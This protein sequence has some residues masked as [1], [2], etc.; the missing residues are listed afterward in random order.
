MIMSV[1]IIQLYMCHMLMSHWW[2]PGYEVLFLILELTF[3][4]FCMFSE[5]PL[6]LNWASRLCVVV[7]NVCVLFTI[8][9]VWWWVHFLIYFCNKLYT[10]LIVVWQLCR[11]YIKQ[12]I[13]FNHC[14]ISSGKCTWDNIALGV[15]A[16]CN[17]VNENCLAIADVATIMTP[18]VTWLWLRTLLELT[19]SHC[20]SKVSACT[21]NIR[22][23]RVQVNVHEMH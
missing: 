5:L 19:A 3:C 20:T 18:V 16:A 14:L 8:N 11:W 4:V 6:N 21:V 2:S 13:I 12:C 23:K 10:L 17:K 22:T 7:C 1:I 9:N 15:T